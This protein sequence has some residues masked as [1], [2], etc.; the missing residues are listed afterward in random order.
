[1]GRSHAQRVLPTARF[2]IP[3]LINSELEKAIEL[4][5]FTQKKKQFII[6]SGFHV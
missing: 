5:P 6:S 4:N 1:M 3:E 2:I